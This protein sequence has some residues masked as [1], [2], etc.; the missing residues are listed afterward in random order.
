VR[1]QAEPGNE[2]CRALAE[3]VLY[4][5][6]LSSRRRPL[7]RIAKIR[8]EVRAMDKVIVSINRDGEIVIRPIK[9]QDGAGGAQSSSDLKA[10]VEQ[11]IEVRLDSRGRLKLPESVRRY[12]QTPRD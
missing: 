2:E 5:F 4:I 7:P 10:L 12:L 11:P 1:S 3:R 8:S 6:H 9:D